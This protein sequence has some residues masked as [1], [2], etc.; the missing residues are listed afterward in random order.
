MNKIIITSEMIDSLYNM[1]ISSN[2]E[3]K[4]TA[5]GILNNRELKNK[6]SEKNVDLLTDKYLTASWGETWARI[7]QRGSIINHSMDSRLTLIKKSL[8]LYGSLNLKNM[9]IMVLNIK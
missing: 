6:E 5:M 2:K 9:K 7:K 3:D 1:L 8:F 4:A